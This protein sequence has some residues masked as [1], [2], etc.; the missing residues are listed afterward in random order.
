VLRESGYEHR[1]RAVLLKGG[2]VINFSLDLGDDHAGSAIPGRYI[3]Y[4]LGQ[5]H[6]ATEQALKGGPSK[7]DI[8]AQK[9]WVRAVNRD[10]ARTGESL[11]HMAW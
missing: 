3:Q 11:D 8:Q 9:E 1:K 5:M 2:K 7:L 6:L 10:L 4:D